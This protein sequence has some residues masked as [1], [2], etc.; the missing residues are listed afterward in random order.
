MTGK[1]SGI[2]DQGARGRYVEAFNCKF[3]PLQTKGGAPSGSFVGRHTWETQEEEIEAFDRK[4]PPF[5]KDAK[6]GAP[7]GSFVT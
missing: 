5:A 1:I 7:S 6:D 3:P 4:S 2:R